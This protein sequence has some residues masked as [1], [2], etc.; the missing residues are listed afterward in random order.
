MNPV[1]SG[2]YCGIHNSP[3]CAAELRAEIAGLHFEFL[4]G[5]R[6]REIDVSGAIQEIH[7]VVI[8]V[9][10]IENVVVMDCG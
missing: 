8:V 9:N 3:A 7:R 1:G 6:G 10:T 5:I 2:L 4:D